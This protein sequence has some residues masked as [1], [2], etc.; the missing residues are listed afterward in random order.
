[1]SQTAFDLN[2]TARNLLVWYNNKADHALPAY[3]NSINNAMLRSAVAAK[4]NNGNKAGDYG[5]TTFVHPILVTG[6]DL[7]RNSANFKH[8]N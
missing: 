7:G 6:E 2:G 3:V 4:D 8:N 1:V 5:I